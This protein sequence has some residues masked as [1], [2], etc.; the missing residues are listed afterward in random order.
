MKVQLTDSQVAETIAH[1]RALVQHAGG[2]MA[3]ASKLLGMSAAVVQG[4]LT[5]NARPG[6][7]VAESAR[8]A[9]DKA[10]SPHI[11]TTA[12]VRVPRVVVAMPAKTAPTQ[13]TRI[14]RMLEELT[15]EKQDI[16]ARQHDL[17]TQLA[18]INR[19]INALLPAASKAVSA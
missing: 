6:R 8:A 3:A 18:E 5:G 11:P 15:A 16:A 7:R 2:N 4:I 19:A 12:P 9:L 14:D 13:P 1:I 10:T 17:A